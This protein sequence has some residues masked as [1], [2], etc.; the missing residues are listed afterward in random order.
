MESTMPTNKD[1]EMYILSLM[2]RSREL[3][4]ELL[5]GLTDEE[6]YFLEHKTIFSEIKAL[7]S[8]HDVNI[9]VL[10]ASL[11]NGG[12]ISDA[13]GDEYLKSL[14]FVGSGADVKFYLDK[15]SETS[16][17]RRLA[18]IGRELWETALKGNGSEDLIL[19][20]MKKISDLSQNADRKPKSIKEIIEDYE[21]GKSYLNV[22]QEKMDSYHETGK[23]FSG[24]LSGYPNLDDLIGGFPNGGFVIIGARTSMGKTTFLLNLIFNIMETNPDMKVGFFSLEMPQEV[25]MGKMACMLSGVNFKKS[26]KGQL[27]SLE[28]EKVE[29]AT[30]E[31][32]NSDSVVFVDEAG[33]RIGKLKSAT[34]RLIIKHKIKILFVDYLTLV[35]SDSKYSN[36]HLEV[37]EISKGLQSLA[38]ELRIPIICLAQLNRQSVGRA[39]KRPLLSDLRESG[40]IEEDAD[41][42]M[43]LHRPKLYDASL[44]EDITQIYVCKNRIFG[45]LGMVQFRYQEGR[46]YEQ[47]KVETMIASVMYEANNRKDWDDSDAL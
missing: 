29:R 36:K 15:L 28:Y 44:P 7:A 21:D 25:L 8:R 9:G 41:L 47:K 19:D 43:M 35:Q 2:L 27:N 23:C 18:M 40:S 16:K 5:C 1:A 13:G 24:I 32:S 11:K 4:D 10:H 37:N 26:Q 42:V 34:R 6:F 45:D 31:L 3:R 38:K 33:L 30:E 12:K 46:L 17:A 20:T 14:A 39:D 22:L